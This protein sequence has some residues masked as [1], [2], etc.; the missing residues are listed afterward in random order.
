MKRKSRAKVRNE[1]DTD[2]LLVAFAKH[3]LRTALQETVKNGRY[4]RYVD[5]S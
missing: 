3:E 1:Q 2:N 4:P 5:V